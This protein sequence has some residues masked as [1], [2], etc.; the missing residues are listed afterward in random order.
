MQYDAV[1]Y[2]ACILQYHAVMPTRH[3]YDAAVQYDAVMY[4][5]CIL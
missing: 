4:D 2:D 3:V 1:M 5:A